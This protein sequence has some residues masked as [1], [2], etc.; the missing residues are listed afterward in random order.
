MHK[1]LCS[2][3]IDQKYAISPIMR[4]AVSPLRD[5]WEY[6][7]L[8]PDILKGLMTSHVYF[9]QLNGQRSHFMMAIGKGQKNS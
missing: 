1:N 9:S 5:T 8:N 2:F 4:R 7:A 6:F 3:E